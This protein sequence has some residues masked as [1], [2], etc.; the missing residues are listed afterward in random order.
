MITGSQDD[1]GRL[2]SGIAEKNDCTVRAYIKR[3]FETVI[4]LKLASNYPITYLKPNR[5]PLGGFGLSHSF[6]GGY[7]SRGGRSSI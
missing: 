5:Y 3:G 4:H 2:E 7:R 6:D 1:A